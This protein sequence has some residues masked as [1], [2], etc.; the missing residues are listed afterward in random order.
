M[1]KVKGVLYWCINREWLTNLKIHKQ[2]PDAE[3][4]PHIFHISRG[5][6]KAKNGMG[7]LLY[8]GPDGT[9]LPSPRL[10]NLRDGLEDYEYLKV[11][12][13]AIERLNKSAIKEKDVLLKESNGLLHIPGNV[14]KSVD[15]WSSN[16]ENLLEYRNKIGLTIS[17][18]NSKLK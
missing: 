3:W 7:N 10:E 18:I 2:W 14:A 1:Y 9:L 16:P 13:N 11:L 12:E 15:S 4:K 6:R 8:P 5:T 17:K